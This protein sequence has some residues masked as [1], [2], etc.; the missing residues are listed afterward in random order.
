MENGARLSGHLLGELRRE[1][2]GSGARSV[3]RALVL[4]LFCFFLLAAGFEA[5]AQTAKIETL[6]RLEESS[7]SEAVRGELQD[8][9]YRVRTE[10][11]TVAAELWF[12]KQIP[13]Q[14][15]AGG[16]GIVYP[17]LAE[18]TLVGVLHFTAASTD[19][20]GQ[21]IP[22]GYYSLRYEL[23]PTDGNHLGAA[24]DRDFLLL[25]PAA[26]DH[27]PK[28]QFKYPDLV[29]LSRQASG[30][31]HPAPL[32]LVDAGD[33]HGPTLSKDDQ[34]RTVFTVSLK[35]SNGSELPI[36]LVVKGSAAQ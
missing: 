9:G 15:G 23:M 21:S 11:G 28:A 14:T 6:A 2:A 32:S 36:A 1:F 30:S 8:S 7:V 19:Y 24:P 34:E 10:D 13:I 20:R 33:V 29:A 31:K 4:S 18:S 26:A 27:D 25:V 16:E 5:R 22:A 35:A 3:S 17:Q 12:R